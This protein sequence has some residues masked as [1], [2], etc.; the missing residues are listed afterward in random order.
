MGPKSPSKKTLKRAT[1][2]ASRTIVSWLAG[3]SS[4]LK[5]HNKRNQVMFWSTFPHDFTEEEEE[6][7]EVDG[8]QRGLVPV[9]APGSDRSHPSGEGPLLRRTSWVRLNW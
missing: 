2:P 4:T 5:N 8:G 6:E 9:S 3:A 1:G 7:E